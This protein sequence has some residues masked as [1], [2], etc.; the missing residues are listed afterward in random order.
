MTASSNK[1]KIHKF[2]FF[3]TIT[4]NSISTDSKLQ[5]KTALRITQLGS[6]YRVQCRALKVT[7][8]QSFDLTSILR[9][10]ESGPNVQTILI[11][12]F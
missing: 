12:L 7:V 5:L 9:C 2:F 4:E 10:A 6:L 1:Q 8:A 11:C 3:R